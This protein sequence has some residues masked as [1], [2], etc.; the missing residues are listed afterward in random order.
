MAL[1][2]E[3]FATQCRQALLADPG[4]S[5]RVQVVHLVQEALKDAGFVAAAL[6]EG[7]PERKVLYEDPDLG[8]TILA[9]AYV[10]AKGSKPH[11]HGPSWAI[12]GQAEGETVMTDFD[13]LARPDGE[14]P[15][16]AK[17]VRDYVLQPGD[18]YLY[19][20][21]VL[22]APRRDGSTKLIRIEGL[23]MDRVK[24]LPYE[25]VE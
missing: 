8:F 3:Q 4:P 1:T 18:A 7:T 13:C 5:G 20:P 17:P 25:A 6:P 22:H 24:R 11:D 12:Y 9:H 21:G 19:E 14:R 16:K 2:I 10:G 23:N 15:G